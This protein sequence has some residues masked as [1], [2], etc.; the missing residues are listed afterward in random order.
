MDNP[1]ICS[2]I[3]NRI[4]QGLE[5]GEPRKRFFE[6]HITKILDKISAEIDAKNL[7]KAE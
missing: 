4:Y 6:D 7:E 1:E 3:Y 2:K 5:E